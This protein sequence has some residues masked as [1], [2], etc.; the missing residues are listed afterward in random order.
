MT[1]TLIVIFVCLFSLICFGL[2]G[3]IEALE[4]DVRQ[5]KSKGSK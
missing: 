5:L 2:V 4:E 1:T 3:R